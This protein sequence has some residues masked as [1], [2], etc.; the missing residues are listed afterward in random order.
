MVFSLMLPSLQATTRKEALVTYVLSCDTGAGFQGAPDGADP[1]LEFTYQALF[2]INANNELAEINQDDI[3]DF[4]NNCK[5]GDYGFGNTEGADSDII[6]T[7][8]ACWIFDLFNVEMYN[9]TYE[10]VAALQNGTEGFSENV[11]ASMTLYAT[12]FGLE[13]LNINGTD[14]SSNNISTWL[15][16]RQNSDS[17]SEGYGGFATDGKTSNMWSTWAAMGSLARMNNVSQV[18]AEPLASWINSSQNL[19]VYEDDCGAFGSKPGETDYSLLTTYTA[20][21][22]LQNLGS[23]YLSRIALETALSW[24]VNL[25]NEDG[26]FR[27]NEMTADSSLSATYY[28]FSILNLLGE[29]GRLDTEAPWD[30]GGGLP[31]WAWILIGIGIALAAILIIRKYYQY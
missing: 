27:V 22:S 15:L 25:Q 20:I 14:L 23:S 18:L 13:A 21:F 11:N 24:L 7:Y 16:E 26:G 12:Y 8:Y 5:N 19:N 3:I 29:Q 6:S 4:V 2:I 30:L 28:A 1:T 10:W 9:Y 31:L 17:G